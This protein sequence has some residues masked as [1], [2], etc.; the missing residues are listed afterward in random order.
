M[1]LHRSA[2]SALKIVNCHD[3]VGTRHDVKRSALGIVSGSRD[4]VYAR[5]CEHGSELKSSAAVI[6]S[7]AAPFLLEPSPS[8]ST[9]NRQ[10]PPNLPRER[11]YRLG[12]GHAAREWLAGEKQL[13]RSITL[14]PLTKTKSQPFEIL[15]RLQRIP[16][17]AYRHKSPVIGTL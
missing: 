3:C 7:L 16:L 5:N 9:R 14:E 15:S 8:T 17:P 11:V 6:G 4:R 2:I 10:R 1:Q 12:P 13:S